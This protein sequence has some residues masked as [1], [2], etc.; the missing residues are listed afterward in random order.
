MAASGPDLFQNDD[1]QNFVRDLRTAAPAAVG[2]QVS[3]A[4]RAVAQAESRL[5]VPVVARSLAALALLLSEFDPA[6]LGSA[7]DP[8]ELAAWF[9]D[10]EIE[11]NPAR[12]QVANGAVNRIVLA[13]DNEWIDSWTGSGQ[14]AEALA[15][16]YRLRDLLADSASEE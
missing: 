1:A 14:L 8:E 3:A 5:T 4:L 12:R 7:P 15:P 13:D 9:A 16:V 10:L 6:V 2:D 11:L